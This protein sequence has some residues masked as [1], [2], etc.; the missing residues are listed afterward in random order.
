MNSTT[1][2]LQVPRDF[3]SA[4][5]SGVGPLPWYVWS[6]LISPVCIIV[7]VYWDISW[8][9]TIGRD[10]FWTPAHLMI[11][12]GAILTAVSSMVLIFGATF[13][14]NRA[15]H[16]PSVKVMGFRGPL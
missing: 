7:G 8:H 1:T 5:V 16:L 14:H 15:S 12:F 13:S 6:C 10:T 3:S 2:A 4:T 11:Q 9:S